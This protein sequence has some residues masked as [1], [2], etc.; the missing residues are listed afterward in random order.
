MTLSIVQQCWADIETSTDHCWVISNV[1]Q[2]QDWCK[3][4]SSVN[5][6]SVC[7]FKKDLFKSVSTRVCIEYCTSCRDA[8]NRIVFFLNCIKRRIC[9]ST[10]KDNGNNTVSKLQTEFKENAYSCLNM[11]VVLDLPIFDTLV[12]MLRVVDEDVSSVA[13]DE[14]WKLQH[15]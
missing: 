10:N 11:T 14:T 7:K 12:D 5:W 9:S 6:A 3:R 2:C 13:L 1:R 8:I 4:Q 15:V